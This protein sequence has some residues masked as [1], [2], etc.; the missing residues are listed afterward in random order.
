MSGANVF[1]A[2][3]KPRFTSS[4]LPSNV[5][6][7]CSTETTAPARVAAGKTEFYRATSTQRPSRALAAIASQ[8]RICSCPSAKVG[9]SG[10]A[11]IPPAA[12]AR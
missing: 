11:G 7:S 10:S 4:S 6:S 8:F 1:R 5:R 12:T 3:R 9:K 2:T